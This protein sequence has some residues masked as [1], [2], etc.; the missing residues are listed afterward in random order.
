MSKA[1]STKKLLKYRFKRT[2]TFVYQEH[3]VSTLLSSLIGRLVTT[4]IF[5]DLL[6]PINAI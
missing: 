5:D 4:Q 3:G 6:Y 1:R 2:D